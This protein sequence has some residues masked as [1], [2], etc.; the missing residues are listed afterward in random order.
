MSRPVPWLFQAAK[1]LSECQY[2]SGNEIRVALAWASRLQNDG[3]PAAYPSQAWLS[4]ATGI[5]RRNV[6][7]ALHKLEAVG[8]VRVK[9]RSHGRGHA[10]EYILTG[11]GERA[12]T[13]PP[14]KGRQSGSVKGGNTC[15][16]RAATLPPHLPSDLPNG[17]E[18]PNHGITAVFGRTA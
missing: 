3:E 18:G 12:A 7:R 6:Q 5:H 9:T 17:S 8:F 10:T 14:I 4:K 1:W 16:K 2:L 15:R 13:V 11:Y